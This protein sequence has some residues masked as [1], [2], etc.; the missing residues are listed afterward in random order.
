MD[1]PTRTLCVTRKV[2]T[3]FGSMYVQI[4]VDAASG[5]PVGGSIAT[6]EKEPDS[7]IT[8]LVYALSDALNAALREI[9]T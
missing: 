7:A 2:K 8:R 1:T 3:E 5:R 9:V 6:P 4:D